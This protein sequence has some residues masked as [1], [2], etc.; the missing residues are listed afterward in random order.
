MNYYSFCFYA[1]AFF[2]IIVI[3]YFLV[4]GG[5]YWL[6]YII[7][8]KSLASRN[9]QTKSKTTSLRQSIY[10]ETKMSVFSG[11]VF[12]LAAAFIMTQCDRGVT[13]IYKDLNQYGYW[14]LGLSFITVLILQDTYFY[15][16][17]RLFH[18][19]SLFKW[20]HK[21]HHLS[22]TPTPWTSFAF[23]VPEAIIQALFFVIIVFI[24]PLHFATLIA[25]LLT[26]TIWS[27]WNHLGFEI[28]PSSFPHHWL[29]KWLIGSTHHNIHHRQYTMH[30][31]L[32]FTFWD[33][34][35]GTQD[36]NY[37]N[38]FDFI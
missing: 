34:L 24:I 20:I 29:G 35:C 38:K 27:I 15:F 26:M 2:L 9:L 19:P 37:Q 17:H 23:D 25:I 1:I 16:L 7:L 12:A 22:G 31:G 36:P 5:A 8:G 6:F 10:R 11:V 21:G 13:L 4:A 32:Y 3:R 33:K 18:H 30:Y 28:F 14:Y